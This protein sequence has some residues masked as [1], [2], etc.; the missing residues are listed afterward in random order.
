MYRP[1]DPVGIPGFTAR[2]MS[3]VAMQ[4]KR[5]LFIDRMI[6]LHA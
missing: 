5:S 2:I 1:V 6:F 3:V 4:Y